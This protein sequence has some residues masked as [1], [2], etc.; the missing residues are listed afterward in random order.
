MINFKGWLA[1]AGKLQAV[2][3]SVHVGIGTG[4]RGQ[5]GCEI[6]RNW[7]C[8][9]VVMGVYWEA[10][11]K[12]PA[13]RDTI[14]LTTSLRF[15]ESACAFS[16]CRHTG[17]SCERLTGQIMHPV[18]PGEALDVLASYR[19]DPNSSWTVIDI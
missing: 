11:L 8:R 18:H 14:Q 7:I 6:G 3:A 16:S 2:W 10:A 12:V 4:K 17:T 15:E 1:G 5:G 19:P 13:L 9:C